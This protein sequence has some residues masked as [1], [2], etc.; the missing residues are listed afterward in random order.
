[1]KWSSWR[2]CAGGLWLSWPSAETPDEQIHLFLFFLSQWWL[3]P[4]GKPDILALFTDTSEW[5]TIHGMFCFC[6]PQ[7]LSPQF[8]SEQSCLHFRH[9]CRS[10]MDGRFTSAVLGCQFITLWR[11]GPFS[12]LTGVCLPSL[13]A[14]EKKYFTPLTVPFLHNYTTS[15]WRALQDHQRATSM[16]PAFTDPGKASSCRAR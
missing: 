7:L 9:I 1:M 8:T 15:G 14:Q 6:V 12:M 11:P 13:F 4:S 5:W 2:L 10:S 16:C 3:K